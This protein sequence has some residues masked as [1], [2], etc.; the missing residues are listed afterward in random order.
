VTELDPLPEIECYPGALNQA[1]M[2][3]LVNGAESLAGS[4]TLTVRARTSD[5]KVRLSVRDTGCGIAEDELRS[6]FEIGFSGKGRRVKMNTGLANVR[7]VVE[8]HHGSIT[9]ESQPGVGTTFEIELP[10]RQPK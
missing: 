10:E 8:K 9:V 7:A 4:G 5:G 2:T 6:I 1:L 3:L